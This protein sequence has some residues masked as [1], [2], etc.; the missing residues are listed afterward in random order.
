MISSM[1]GGI[2]G[3]P[4]YG[5]YRVLIVGDSTTYGRGANPAGTAG[6][7]G[8]HID[9]PCRQLSRELSKIGVSASSNSIV[10]MGN[11]AQPESTELY[12]NATPDVSVTLNGWDSLE[13]DSIGG[14][15]FRSTDT[16]ILTFSFDNVDK[17][18]IGIPIR[19]YGIIQY[20]V[21]GG[22]WIQESQTGTDTMKRIEIDFISKGAHTVEFQY[23]SGAS[24]Y[25][26]Y[27]EA[28]DSSVN[29][30]VIAWGARGYTSGQLND[31]VRPWSYMSALSLVPFDILIINIG[32]N[33]VRIGGS[34]ISQLTYESNVI[35]YINAAKLAQPDSVIYIQ[36]PNDIDTGLSYL[37]V[38]ISNIANS[39]SIA[40]LDS[41]LADG[42]ANYSEADTGGLM[43]D[44]LHPNNIGYSSEWSYFSSILKSN[45]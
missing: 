37:P 23:V 1:V 44:S 38:A 13:F 35:A 31:T 40:I 3:A 15:I 30:S 14:D 11:N 25:V 26:N 22:S 18:A 10:G 7:T 16:T 2:S 39:E 6:V 17:G 5:S 43:Y 34:G 42:M 33:D 32:I 36:I 29:V 4:S 12:Y 8:A 21:D 27:V 9:S 45:L 19:A 20:R 24:V 28:W 41:R